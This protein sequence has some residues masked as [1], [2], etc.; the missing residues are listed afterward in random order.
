MEHRHRRAITWLA[1]AICLVAGLAA[2]RDAAALQRLTLALT[3]SRDPTLLQEVGQELAQALSRHLGMPV[4]VQVASDYA[5]VI[6]ALRSQLVD[7]AFLPAVGYVLAARQAGARIVVK[8]MRGGLADY[9]ARFF[10]RQDSPYQHLS[11]LR[12]KTIAFVDP[13]SSSGYIYPMVL[14]IKQGLVRDRDPK[15]FFRETLFAG[16]HDAALL[17]LLNGSVDAAVTFAEAPERLLKEAEKIARLRSLAE[18]PR[19]P[20][21]GAAVRRDLSAEMIQRITQA[22]LALNNPQ[23]VPL[24]QRLYGIDG[25]APAQDREYDPVREAVDLLGVR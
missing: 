6:E 16:S 18:T 25:L 21:D 10:V 13:A 2:E 4:R 7:A 8:A 11:D 20:N 24:L 15:T 14:L 3:P 23:D 17:S 1:I 22:L 9:T 19:I 5:S 12:G